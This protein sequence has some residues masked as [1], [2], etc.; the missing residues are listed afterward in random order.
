[1]SRGGHASGAPSHASVVCLT[2][3]AGPIGHLAGWRREMTLSCA[4]AGVLRT[5]IARAGGSSRDESFN[6]L[7]PS[8][9]G[10]KKKRP[11][12]EG[13]ITIS[14]PLFSLMHSTRHRHHV[15]R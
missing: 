3:R 13:L 14:H 5:L 11:N 7:D 15:G 4:W 1:M 9:K 6:L 10:E 12:W 8:K 2:R